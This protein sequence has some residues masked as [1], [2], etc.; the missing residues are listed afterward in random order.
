MNY[1]SYTGNARQ[2]DEGE[3]E[4]NRSSVTKENVE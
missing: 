3:S 2:L 4:L 1:F